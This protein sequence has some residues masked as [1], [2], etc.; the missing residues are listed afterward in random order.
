MSTVTTFENTIDVPPA[1][2]FEESDFDLNCPYSPTSSLKGVFVRSRPNSMAISES[3]LPSEFEQFGM[4]VNATVP[5]LEAPPVSKARHRPREPSFR[6]DST[7]RTARTMPANAMRAV[8][9]VEDDGDEDEE[10][11]PPTAKAPTTRRGT[12]PSMVNLRSRVSGIFQRKQ[13]PTHSHAPPPSPTAPSASTSTSSPLEADI[14]HVAPRSRRTFFSLRS[15]AS[16]TSS[17]VP[18][19]HTPV[20][21]TASARTRRVRRSRSFSGFTS[22]AHAVLAP[23][24]DADAEPEEEELDE[25]GMEAYRTARGVGLF[26][27]YQEEDEEEEEETAA[28]GILERGVEGW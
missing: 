27:V 16:S 25:V 26:W 24:A 15:R 18:P 3:D 22:M 1:L 6:D 23:I 8:R 21:H 19:S 5:F 20:G 2:N 17:K 12:W 14:E 4:T 9:R 28:A 13:A 7:V 10:S 11:V